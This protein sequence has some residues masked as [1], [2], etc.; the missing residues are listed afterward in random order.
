MSSA[1]WPF[2]NGADFKS[3]EGCLHFSNIKSHKT[4]DLDKQNDVTR[5]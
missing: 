4:S 5:H 3:P 1:R 2:A